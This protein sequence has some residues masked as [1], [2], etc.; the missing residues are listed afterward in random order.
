M[1]PLVGNDFRVG[2]EGAFGVADVRHASD[3]IAGRHELAVFEKFLRRDVVFGKTV[4]LP[5]AEKVLDVIGTPI[6]EVS[7]HAV[8]MNEVV[9]AP[10]DFLDN[11][12][13]GIQP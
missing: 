1:Q 11:S 7:R 9:D 6:N 5:R 2:A 10:A 8:R 3:E 12:P 13:H 4:V